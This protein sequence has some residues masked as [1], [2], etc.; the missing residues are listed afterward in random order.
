MLDKTT[1]SSTGQVTAVG[2]AAGLVVL[3][4]YK[5]AERRAL[6]ACLE[7]DMHEQWAAPQG[8]F[9]VPGSCF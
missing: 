9:L 4:D 2:S 8:K 5:K 1:C 3:L 6:F 7:R